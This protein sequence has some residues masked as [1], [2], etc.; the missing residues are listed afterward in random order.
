MKP[1]LSGV[2]MIPQVALS[3]L[4]GKRAVSDKFGYRWLLGKPVEIFDG[5]K[6]KS[7]NTFYLSEAL[8]LNAYSLFSSSFVKVH[9]TAPYVKMKRIKLFYSP[10]LCVPGDFCHA[11]FCLCW[12]ACSQFA[13]VA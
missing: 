5:Y 1:T 12:P 8:K 4:C 11:T 7:F 6:V 9:I 10:E 13:N 3:K 2:V